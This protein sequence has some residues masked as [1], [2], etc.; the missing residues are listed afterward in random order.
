MPHHVRIFAILEC[1]KKKQARVIKEDLRVEDLDKEMVAAKDNCGNR[2]DPN[3]PNASLL[4]LTC[5]VGID[6]GCSIDM[7]E[8]NV[9]MTKKMKHARVDLF[10]KNGE[11]G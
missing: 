3:C 5:L 8:H 4:H 6:H 1:K 2:L 10:Q 7:V 9:D 11:S